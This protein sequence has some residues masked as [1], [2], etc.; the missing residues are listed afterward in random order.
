MSRNL[1]VSERLATAILGLGLAGVVLFAIATG[2][3]VWSAP[4][5]LNAGNP[6][7]DIA[8]AQKALDDS[9]TTARSI[10]ASLASTTS[11]IDTTVAGLRSFESALRQTAVL[12]GQFDLLGQRPFTALTQLFTTTADLAAATATSLVS[13]SASIQTTRTSIGPL[14][15]DLDRLSAQL[16]KLSTGPASLLSP[17]AF[18]IAVA[19][20]SWLLVVAALIA[21][22]GWVLR[23]DAASGATQR[24]SP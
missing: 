8:T 22:L 19:T 20:L 4:S 5:F 15:A 17:A 24:R 18:W 7:S 6:T 2:A 3:L 11:A 14:A 16:T 1:V 13:V 12:F 21:R 10:E 23:L 9:A